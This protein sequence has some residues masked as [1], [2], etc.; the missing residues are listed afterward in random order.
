VSST[1]GE[2]SQQVEKL[3]DAVPAGVTDSYQMETQLRLVVE[4]VAAVVSLSYIELQLV[5]RLEVNVG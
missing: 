1:G 2:S 4:V 3:A 5:W